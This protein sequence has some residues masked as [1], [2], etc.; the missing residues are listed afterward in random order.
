MIIM[1]YTHMQVY[2]YALYAMDQQV[3]EFQIYISRDDRLAL[4]KCVLMPSKLLQVC[5]SLGLHEGNVVIPKTTNT[6]RILENL[7]STGLS[8]DGTDIEKMRVLNRNQR[9]VTGDF[10]FQPGETESD[11]WDSKNDAAFVT[12]A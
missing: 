1:H 12:E 6:D 2:M 4:L 10:L 5:I 7:K 8:L 11:F 3:H 9:F